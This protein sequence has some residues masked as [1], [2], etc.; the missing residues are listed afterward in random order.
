MKKEY[1]IQGDPARANEIKAA[2]E[3]E[4]CTLYRLASNCDSEDLI[5][6][7]L[8]G[9]VRGIKKDNLY[10]FEAHPGYKELELQVQPKFKVGDTIQY[11]DN[12]YKII[13]IHYDTQH[14]LVD[15]GT[16]G[17]AVQDCYHLWT[18]ADAKDGDVLATDNGWA[19]I[20]QAFDGWT[21]SSYCFMDSKNWFCEFG[22]EVHTTDSRINGN[23]HPA[24]KV[25]RD[26]FFK[27]MREAGYQW[28]PGKKELRKII[29]PNFKTGDWIV[30]ND[31]S[32]IVPIQVYGLKRDRYL[33]T[34]MLGSKGKLM[35]NRQD[36]W[37]LWTIADAKDGDVLVCSDWL[38]ILKRFNVK[39]NNHKTYCHYDLTLNHFKDD[40]D[41]YMVS[42]SDEF[43]PANKV[44][45]ELL[46]AKMRE[47]GYEWDDKKKK[48][49]LVI[50]NGG[51]FFESEN[52]EQKP[53]DKVESKFKVGDWLYPNCNGIYPVLVTDYN[54]CCGYQ[55]QEGSDR[56]HLSTKIVEDKYHLWSIKDA[57]DGDVLALNG[58]PFIYSHKYEKNYC[59][60]DDCGQFRVNFSIVL[61]GNCVC[62]A[63]KQERDL[64]FSKM[65][66][67]GYE[68]D[69]KKKELRKIQPHY[70]I[71]NFR[72]GMPVL[73]REYDTCHWQ[74]VQYSHFNGVGLFFAAGK[75]W[76]QCIPFAG[77]EYLLGT[78]DMCDERFIN[79]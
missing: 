59:Y 41:S 46:F 73:V 53:A 9:R 35:I 25:Q 63:T 54:K 31:G 57:K 62:P 70:D 79:W 67:V 20:F 29:E 48:L 37:H 8:N 64:L 26:L 36:E 44:Q 71:A 50:T 56:C 52:C 32:S 24:T 74:W 45:C 40:T 30:R 34:N 22:S 60:I 3:K 15:G 18:I 6:Y 68:W 13:G 23:I 2:F 49:K 21:F 16:I 5:Y 10:L 39:G 55:L 65:R 77:N 7:S 14:Y 76:R 27:R 61:E 72:V 51:D 1:Y 42:G 38:F 28:N 69:K 78:T 33:V 66:E 17:F 11:K 19:C 58:K 12:T 43:H 47:A 4:G 75:T